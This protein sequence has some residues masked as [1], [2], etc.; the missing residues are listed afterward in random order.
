MKVKII[1][2]SPLLWYKLGQ[3]ITV[4][5]KRVCG[6]FIENNPPNRR[7]HSQDCIEVKE[8]I[9]LHPFP[10]IEKEENNLQEIHRN[11]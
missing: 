9:S 8:S 3:I 11:K 6:C 5:K 2:T 4:R 10:G 7:I 1:N